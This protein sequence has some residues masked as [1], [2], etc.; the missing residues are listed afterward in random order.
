MEKKGNLKVNLVWQIL[1]QII[2][3]M[4]PLITTP[5]V[6]RI[7]GADLIGDNSYVITIA[8][9]FVMFIM[10]GINN[11]GSRM[12]SRIKEDKE[13]LNKKF[14][15]L[16]YFHFI[17]SIL[18]ICIYVILFSVLNVPKKELYWIALLYLI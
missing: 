17:L 16:I 2:L 5:Y 3:I 14:S 12:I 6:S 7:L 10:L 4:V 1:Y 11:H 18:I 15:S 13:E 9:Y 8:N